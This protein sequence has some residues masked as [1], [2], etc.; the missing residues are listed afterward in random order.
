MACDVDECRHMTN[1]SLGGVGGVGRQRRYL[2]LGSGF[3]VE[4]ADLHVDIFA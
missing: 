3:Q 4:F 2:A 1:D